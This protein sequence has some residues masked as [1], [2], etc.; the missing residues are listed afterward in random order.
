MLGRLHPHCS[1]AQ[2][3]LTI[4]AAGAGRRL[5]ACTLACGCALLVPETVRGQSAA[6]PSSPLALAA[7][8]ADDETPPANDS[9]AGTPA[10]ELP[11]RG[12][13]QEALAPF[14]QL[15]RR[16]VEGDKVPGAALAVG[17]EGRVV[18]ARGF[19]YADVEAQRPVEPTSLFRIASISKPITAVAILRMVERG[20]LALD[21]PIV[22]WVQLE[23]HRVDGIAPDERLERVTILDCLR[24]TGGWDR[25]VSYDPM[26]RSVAF[27]EALSIA[28]PA[29]ARD[30][31]R[32]MFGQPLDFDPG[33]RYAYSN[34]GYCVL[35]RIIEEVAG[36]PYE[37]YVRR[38]VLAPLGITEMRIGHTLAEERFPGEVKYYD[39]D[40]RRGKAV[41]AGRV[42]EEVDLPYG[43][44]FQESLDAHGGWIA[45]AVDLVRFGLA[46]AP[47]DGRLLSDESL[48][49]CDARPNGAAG[50]AE[51]GSPKDVHYGCGWMVRSRGE[52]GANLWHTGS[53]PGTSTLLVLRHD[54]LVWAALF[55]TRNAPGGQRL[56]QQVD[57][58][59][60]RAAAQVAEWPSIDLADA[61]L[62]AADQEA[63]GGQ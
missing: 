28:P 39:E 32:Y 37:D 4:R 24:H 59:L 3:A 63:I 35:G 42:G 20:Q 50:Y 9:A 7:V 36:E 18:Y 21:D 51:D 10:A 14:D 43:T 48:A 17:R 61:L 16:L 58:G 41:V 31:I 34:F 49:L 56:S 38:D 2:P 13:A 19:G 30:V 15:M 54:G 46:L 52:G 33:T 44:W 11:C 60:H 8:V 6:L 53:L 5:F 62:P 1:A 26:F 25:D 40:R 55:N 29:A 12:P 45:S 27:A 47:G 57:G 23:P 22:R